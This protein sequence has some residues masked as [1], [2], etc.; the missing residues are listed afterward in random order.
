MKDG[1]QAQLC[2]LGADGNYG[3]Y[4]PNM[5]KWLNRTQQTEYFTIF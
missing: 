4:M 1:F 3:K 5:N 2:T